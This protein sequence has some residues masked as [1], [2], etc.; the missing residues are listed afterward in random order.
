[1]SSEEEDKPAEGAFEPESDEDPSDSV[2]DEGDEDRAEEYEEGNLPLKAADVEVPEM[3]EED[4]EVRLAMEMA[5]AAAQNPGMSPDQLRKLV[6]E[7][8]KQA[9]I[10]KEVEEKKAQEQAKEMQKKKEEDTKKWNEQKASYYNWFQSIS[11]GSEEYQ[12]EQTK[13]KF[14]AEIKKDKK[15]RETRKA[16]K[17]KR[18]NLKAQR[19][20]GNRVETRHIFKRQRMEK[21]FVEVSAAIEKNRKI[22][23]E[24]NYDAT[25]YAKAMMKA[26]KKWNKK[27]N[28]DEELALE[29]QLCRNM[30]QMLAL[31]KQKSKCK[32]QLK[33]IKKYLQRCKSWLSDKQ[34]LCELHMLTLEATHNSMKNI[35]EDTLDRQDKFIQKLKS[36]PEFE[37]QKDLFENVDVSRYDEIPSHAGPGA[38]LN[39]LRGLPFRDDISLSSVPSRGRLSEGGGN[40][41][42]AK[43]N[44]VADV[45]VEIDGLPSNANAG[46]KKHLYVETA[47]DG[48]SIN[49]ALTDPDDGA[50][51]DDPNLSSEVAAMADSVS[52]IIAFGDDAP[53]LKQDTS[54]H[55]GDDAN[56][57]KKHLTRR[58]HKS[59]SNGDNANGDG[60]ENG[61]RE[62][63]K[64]KPTDDPAADETG[65]TATEEEDE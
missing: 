9:S 44:G 41:K 32:K 7:K 13:L 60:G 50:V 49:S 11:Q 64:A 45:R 65:A 51:A 17:V 8:N 24:T 12:W 56:Q 63:L 43:S 16:I 46:D 55:A 19:L 14:A 18:K 15:I 20:Q 54:S 23:C 59:D 2:I 42:A 47:D 57:K 4:D 34:A 6:G 33:E 61:G 30:H 38:T 28:N 62:K 3:E 5:L 22:F 52:G 37:E 27:P 29:A 31:E 40:R 35:Y 25:S 53:W 26:S 48:A 58:P 1:M 39:A 21:H 36:L 10:V